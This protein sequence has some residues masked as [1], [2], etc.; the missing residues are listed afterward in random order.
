MNIEKR[1]EDG[2]VG[3]GIV[4][5]SNEEMRPCITYALISKCDG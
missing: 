5:G 1:E 2:G 3:V 4:V